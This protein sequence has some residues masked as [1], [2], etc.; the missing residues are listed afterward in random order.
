M[1]AGRPYRGAC[2]PNEALERLREGA[3]A[4]FDPK[5]VE[6]FCQVWAAEEKSLE[7]SGQLRLA[8]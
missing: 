1:T 7:P 6:A 8:R 5:V 4:Q 2:S 3:G